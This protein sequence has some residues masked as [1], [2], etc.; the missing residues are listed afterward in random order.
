MSKFIY[1]PQKM[2][3]PA[4]QAFFYCKKRNGEWENTNK[5]DSIFCVDAVL[6]KEERQEIILNFAILQNE[7]KLY[8]RDSSL[9]NKRNQGVVIT[10]TAIHYIKDEVQDLI[11]VFWSDIRVIKEDAEN[12]ILVTHEDEIINIS[13]DAIIKGYTFLDEQK[14]KSSSKKVLFMFQTMADVTP[15][16]KPLD[17]RFILNNASYKSAKNNE[18]C[19]DSVIYGVLG[20]DVSQLQALADMHPYIH[21]IQ[22]FELF[23]QEITERIE[24]VS[25][26]IKQAVQQIQDSCRYTIINNIKQPNKSLK[27]PSSIFA[28]AIYAATEIYSEIKENQLEQKKEIFLRN[29]KRMQNKWYDDN[30]NHIA[31]KLNLLNNQIKN[32]DILVNNM[33]LKKISASEMNELQY[34]TALGCLALH[35][36][37]VYAQQWTA[38]ILRLLINMWQQINKDIHFI[39]M[40]QI[41]QN[42]YRKLLDKIDY[43]TDSKKSQLTSICILLN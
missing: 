13:K 25:T 5:K 36:R 33:L 22:N 24:G 6:S 37:L 28:A 20:Y 39:P 23:Q 34:N 41:I 32:M 10:D 19:S 30:F 4:Y 16:V 40:E 8:F 9:F 14:Q 2:G 15:Y 38:S 21:T 12:F 17:Y 27:D 35:C 43:T 18:I 7:K 11:T 26:N 42:E 1:N 31:E 3:N 29:C